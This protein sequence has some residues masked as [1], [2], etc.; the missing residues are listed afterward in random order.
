MVYSQKQ[1]EAV[2]RFR[3][4]NKEEF[5]IKNKEYMKD[6]YKKNGDQYKKERLEFYYSNKK[7]DFKIISKVFLKILL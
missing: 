6:Y 5:D 1:Y 4:K 3:I 2:K 7:Y